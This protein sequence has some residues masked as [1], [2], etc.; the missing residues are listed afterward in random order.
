MANLYSS[1]RPGW[2]MKRGVS[3]RGNARARRSGQGQHDPRQPNEYR[4]YCC[5]CRYRPNSPR[6]DDHRPPLPQQASH[7]GCSDWVALNANAMRSLTGKTATSTPPIDQALKPLTGIET[8]F[9]SFFLE[10]RAAKVPA[11]CAS[12]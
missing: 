10:L 11:S 9:I 1:A 7:G 6:I 2:P 3:P 4:Q 5:R 8:M 12:S